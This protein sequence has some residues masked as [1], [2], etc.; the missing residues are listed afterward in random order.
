MTKSIRILALTLPLLF[1]TACESLKRDKHS[2]ANTDTTND[3]NLDQPLTPVADDKLAEHIEQPLVHTDI[4]SRIRSGYALPDIEHDTINNHLRWYANNQQHLDTFTERSTPYIHYVVSEL[5]ANNMPLELAL[6]PVIESSYNPFA[7]S[8]RRAAGIWQFMP[9]TGSSF[10]LEQNG[11]Y[12]GRRDLIASTDAAIRYL[13]QLHAMFGEDWLL[14]L[15][16]YNAGQG[17]VRRAIRKNEAA[18]KP[19]DFWSLPLPKQTR[20]YV[21]RLLALSRIIAGPENYQLTLGTIPN[22]PYFTPID[23]ESQ[24]NLAEV[25]K[26]ASIDV[27]EIQSL[28]AGYSRWLTAPSGPHQVLVPI[29]AATTFM[30]HLEALPP[31]PVVNWHE[32]TVKKGDNLGAIA[33]RFNTSVATIKANNQLKNDFLR[34]GQVL[35][36]AGAAAVPNLPTEYPSADELMR[37]YGKRI[38]A[39]STYYTVRPG[40]SLWKIARS[41]DTTVNTLTRMNN[42]SRSS[43]LKPGQKLLVGAQ[44]SLKPVA[45]DTPG[46]MVYEVQRGDT[47][48]GIASRF[49]LSTKQILAWNSVKDARYIHPGQTLTLFLKQ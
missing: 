39:N 25:A 4:W 43:K 9:R 2:S 18:G 19:T 17:T 10:G 38:T 27:Q 26:L 29:D 28:N 3:L 40:D 15:A 14:A 41:H 22:D 16:A 48:H 8:S 30:E 11:W 36:V 20:E 32:Y 21:P 6:L 46:K 23:V 7:Y 49:K 13:Q 47:L 45:T 31:R 42:M 12:D 35:Q 44:K 33:R 1:L 37:N 5:E 34:I 24:I